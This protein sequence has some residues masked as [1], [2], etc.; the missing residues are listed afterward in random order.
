MQ[1]ESA[2]TELAEL[3]GERA[4]KRK[5][6]L[7]NKCTRYTICTVYHIFSI[8]SGRHTLLNVILTHLDTNSL[9]AILTLTQCSNQPL[10][11]LH[12]LIAL[13]LMTLLVLG[14]QLLAYAVRLAHHISDSLERVDNAS[15]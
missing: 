2:H 8:A 14:V 9:I 4:S 10:G 3:V 15:A 11:I 6:R 7:V 12:T 13:E 5:T 1:C